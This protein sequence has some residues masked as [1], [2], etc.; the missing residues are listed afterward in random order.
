MANKGLYAVRQLFFDRVKVERE[1]D[2][3]TRKALSRFGAFVR[4][5]DQTSQRK[6]K[7]ISPPGQ[8]PYAH[9]GLLRKLTFFAYDPKTRSVVIGPVPI[10]AGS[11]V[12]E[13]LEYG[14]SFQGDGRVILVT[15]AVGRDASGR[16]VSGGRARVKLDGTIRYPARPHTR[17][18]FAA[19][20][21]KA[22]GQFK[23]QMG[24]S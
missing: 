8:P 9:E 7:G 19:E 14:G 18:A 6:R 24:A 5:R 20:L 22:A 2:R 11:L 1:M 4:R 21:P 12:P 3:A 23:D 10:K 17:P 13:T 15:N 16:F